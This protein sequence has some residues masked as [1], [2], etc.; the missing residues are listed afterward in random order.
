M[1]EYSEGNKKGKKYY[2]I[3]L[4][5]DFLFSDLRIKKL[6]K[7]AGGDTY[8]IIYLKLM[9]LSKNNKGVIE[10]EGIENNVSEELALK[11]DEDIENIKMTISYLNQT[12]LLEIK[13]PINQDI[14]LPQA[15][16]LIGSESLSAERVRQFRERQKQKKILEASVTPLLQCNTKTL[17]CNK[18]V[19]KCNDREEKEKI[20]IEKK[21]EL[22]KKEKELDSFDFENLYE[23]LYKNKE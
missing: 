8:T 23:E 7:I 18:V 3:K 2:W 11:L 13:D 9:L 12:G 1:G 20:R 21:I 4:T 16:T 6:R 15:E 14:Y 10:Y 17:H 5:D 22:N 19:T